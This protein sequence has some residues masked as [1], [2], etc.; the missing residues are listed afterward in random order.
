MSMAPVRSTRICHV[1][2]DLLEG[3]CHTCEGP[4]MDP[5]VRV[6]PDTA[7]TADTERRMDLIVERALRLADA[8]V[9]VP[10]G[11]LL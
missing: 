5:G 4:R 9:A 10:D 3:G 7:D 6:R 2:G 11:D 8:E 1:C